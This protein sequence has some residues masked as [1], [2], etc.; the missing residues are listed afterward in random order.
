M[1]A[2]ADT[3]CPWCLAMASCVLRPGPGAK[4]RPGIS[5]R[6]VAEGPRVAAPPRVLNREVGW[7]RS[8]CYTF[9]RAF[10]LRAAGCGQTDPAFVFPPF[11]TSGVA[12]RLTPAVLLLRVSFYYLLFAYLTSHA[13]ATVSQLSP[14]TKFPENQWT[15]GLGRVRWRHH[16]ARVRVRISRPCSAPPPASRPPPPAVELHRYPRPTRLWVPGVVC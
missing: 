3:C 4:C 2:K 10:L 7:G 15:P 13:Q 12:P 16:P 6:P 1:I 11:S 8:A 5:G 14:G 9:S